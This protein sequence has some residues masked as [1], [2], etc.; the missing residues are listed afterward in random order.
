MAK[1]VYQTY[2]DA[3]FQLAVEE[4]KVDELFSETKAMKEIFEKNE[5]LLKLLTNPKI[6]KQEKLNIVE[7]IFSGRASKDLVGFLKVIITK[8]RQRYVIGIFDYF[9][10]AAKEYKK[11]G[12]VYVTTAIPL[13]DIGREKVVKK[14]L[15][16]TKYEE[17]EMNYSVDAEIIG[18]M[19]IRIGDRV[20][21]STIRTK[22]TK[23]SKQL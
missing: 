20:V 3:L 23:L 10:A 15:E 19:I 18:G 8:D 11:I 14:L 13:D 6:D 5:E 7:N 1:L 12:V 4:N 9:I 2:G 21:D 17:L 22:I 16:T